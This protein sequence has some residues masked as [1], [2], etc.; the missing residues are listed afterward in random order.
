MI[1]RVDEAFLIVFIGKIKETTYGHLFAQFLKFCWILKSRSP[2]LL[3]DT[4]LLPSKYMHMSYE[5]LFA[6]C[7]TPQRGGAEY[8]IA[9]GISHEDVMTF[10]TYL[11]PGMMKECVLGCSHST[12][13]GSS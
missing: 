5:P 8:V 4:V 2:V 1:V 6:L 3:C 10:K 11:L 9:A 7:D 12:K 13:N